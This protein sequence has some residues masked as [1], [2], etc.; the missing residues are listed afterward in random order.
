GGPV[1]T[2]Y[3]FSNNAE[4]KV[5]VPMAKS[6]PAPVKTPVAAQRGPVG[7]MQAG[8]ATALKAEPDWQEF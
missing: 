7:R 5:A 6:K 4:R 8:L 1:S 3:A 2:E